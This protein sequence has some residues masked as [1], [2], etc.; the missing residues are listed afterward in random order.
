[1]NKTRMFTIANFIEHIFGSPSHNNQ[2]R[3]RNKRN[4]SKKKKKEAKLSLL[5]YTQ[6][7]LKMPPDDY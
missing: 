1:M 4:S 2:K 7:I 3:T 5:C 6:K